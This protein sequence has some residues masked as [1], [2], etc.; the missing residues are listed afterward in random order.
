MTIAKKIWKDHSV[1]FASLENTYQNVRYYTGKKGKMARK[2]RIDKGDLNQFKQDETILKRW[3]MPKSKAPSKRT[4]QIPSKYNRVLWISDIHFPNHDV[5]ALTTALEYGIEH[6]ANCIVIGGDLLDMAPF[7]RFTVPPSAKFARD[8]FDQTVAF[9]ASLRKNF[10]DAHIIYMQG[11]HDKW[12][13]TWLMTKCAEVFDDPYYQLETRL[14]LDQFNI[15]F[16]PETV[17]VKAGKLPMLHGHTIVRGVFAPVNSARGAYVKSNHNLLIG[18]THQ[19]SVHSAKD[20]MG[21]S[22][23]TWSTGCLCTLTPDYDPHNIRH[24]HGFAFITTDTNGEFTVRNFEIV[25]G[26]IR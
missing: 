5:K 12:Y 7:T 14:K 24:T 3:S 13:E 9:L 10:P 23:K 19:V 15:L 1:L 26:K 2:K 11:N 8:I 16:Q 20:L 18:H 22:T 17:I 25:N 21:R 4:Y 6:E